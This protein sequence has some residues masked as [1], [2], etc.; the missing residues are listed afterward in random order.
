MGVCLNESPHCRV[1]VIGVVKQCN[2]RNINSYEYTSLK[3]LVRTAHSAFAFDAFH[4][5][6]R[7]HR[8]G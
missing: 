6:T 3:L 5:D 8:L 2:G 4:G 1:T 7:Y